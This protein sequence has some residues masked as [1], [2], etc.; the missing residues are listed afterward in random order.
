MFSEMGS[1]INLD[2]SK[3]PDVTWDGTMTATAE[4]Y[5]TPQVAVTKKPR[6]V[7]IALGTSNGAVSVV[8]L[9]DT[10]YLVGHIGATIY[11]LIPTWL[12]V[13]DSYVQYND[14]VQYAVNMRIWY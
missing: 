12:F 2:I 4:G 13:T 14:S 6:A 7:L 1:G 5:A 9:E 11:D 3:T 10:C 8:W